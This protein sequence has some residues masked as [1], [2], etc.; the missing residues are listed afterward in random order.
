MYSQS[1][2]ILLIILI[3][4]SATITH[5]QTNPYT[6]LDS[7]DSTQAIINRIAPPE[8]FTRVETTPGSF[9]EWLRY[10]P[11]KEGH[12]PIYLYNGEK[13]NLQEAHSAIVN[14]DTGDD[15]LQQCADAV[16]R[17][18]AE[19]LYAAGHY[20]SIAF[21]F[22]SGDLFRYRDWL[23]GKTPVINGNEV[24]W[25]Q[26]SV[27]ENNRT[28]FHEYL[29]IIFTYAGSYSLSRELVKVTDID[30][31]QPGDVF[32][33]GGF[34][35]HAMLVVDVACKQESGEKIF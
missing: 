17:L 30:S 15:D 6:W 20:D 26:Q 34:P 35:G 24:S 8:G 27:R 1:L 18:R 11:L 3:I 25:Q 14:I 31:I 29:K 23:D 22:T 32:I 12:P 9:G 4:T 33:Q 13:K 5:S 2:K 19:Y 28:T 21:N 7:Y 10:L 16:I